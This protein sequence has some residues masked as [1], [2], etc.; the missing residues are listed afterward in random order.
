MPITQ[1][2]TLALLLVDDLPLVRR[3]LR[4]LLESQADFTV[5]GEAGDGQ[6]ALHLVETLSPDV[7]VMDVTMP[8]INGIE[9][10]QRILADAPGTRIVALSIRS[11]RRFVDDILKAG[12]AAYVLKDTAPEELVPAIHAVM[13]GEVFMSAPILS[14]VVSEYKNLVDETPTGVIE[15]PLE[16]SLILQTKLHRPALPRDLV[17]RT[18]LVS[19]LEK[20]RNRP[21]T[22]VSAP[23]GY[24]KSTLISSW[25]E[26]CDWPSA[27]ISLDEDQSDI[28]QFLIYFVSAV[29]GLFPDACQ[30]S[31]N[32]AQTAEPPPVA[33]LGNTL[34]NELNALEQP[35][36]LILDDYQRI[37]H[38]SAV[39]DLLQQLLHHPPIPLHLVIASRRDPPLALGALRAAG[40]VTDLRM[41]ELKFNSMEVRSL[42]EKTR[43]YTASDEELASLDSEMEGWAVGLRLVSI[44]SQRIEDPGKFLLSLRGGVQHTQEYLFQEVIDQLSSE[45]LDWLLKCA[46]LDRFCEGLCN[47]VCTKDGDSKI[48]SVDAERFIRA[49]VD[50][51][52]F[53]VSLDIQGHWYRYHHLFQRL[54]QT[55]L[56]Q[57]MSAKEIT[58]LHLRA[59]AWFESQLLIDEA[60][61]YA[62]KAGDAVV[63]ADIVQRHYHEEANQDRWYSLA[64]WLAKIPD[65]IV[66]QRPLL[67]LARAWVASYRWRQAILRPI[68]DA[69]ESLLNDEVDDADLRLELDF[70]RGFL[71]L[72]DG[73]TEQSQA[74]LESVVKRLTG[75]KQIFLSKAEA[76]LSF[77]RY[78]N[79]N[80]EDA[81]RA[82]NDRILNS[83]QDHELLLPRMVGALAFINLLSGDLPGARLEAKRMHELAVPHQSLM[84]IAWA[85]QLQGLADLHSMNLEAALSHFAAASKYVHVRGTRAE[86]EA[87][88]GIA[89]TQQLMRQPDAAEST[90]QRLIQF[91]YETNDPMHVNRARFTE[92]RIQLLQ[93]N[94]AAVP[95]WTKTFSEPLNAFALFASLEVSSITKARILIADGS[96]ESLRE[97]SDLLREM[98]DTCDT[99]RLTCQ[100]IEIAVLQS[101]LLEK[102]GRDEAA[103]Q[104]LEEA[105][106]LAAPGGWIRPF[107]EAGKPMAELLGRRADQKGPTHFVSRIIGEF[108]STQVQPA[109]IAGRNLRSGA[110]GTAWDRESLTPRELDILQLLAKRLQNKEIAKQLFVSP[111]TVKSHLK[112]LYQKLGVSNRREA[113]IMAAEFQETTRAGPHPK[114]AG[115][116]TD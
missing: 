96:I 25:L 100:A 26:D 72:R 45:L 73:N 18:K 80:G 89:L 81:V 27:W 94:L 107:V 2:D 56:S 101:L 90:I 82:I 70:F 6:E 8:K 93:G 24:G 64:R 54:L 109:R 113:G 48:P 111:E 31:R 20:H 103:M 66:Q 50:E 7:V 61:E 10:T 36:I 95:D 46:I 76:H 79:G 44:A 22:L 43:A 98:R 30:D 52:L 65:M 55:R 37:N 88:A 1:R 78:M 15:Q 114:V 33:D 85:L 28:Q 21:L 87:L 3:G 53:A 99:H 14:S 68:V 32:L 83:R 41:H 13:R 71:Q 57:H 60:I 116:D 9:A 49:L 42:L 105:L 97:A 77:A 19:Q 4:A 104:S 35:F 74:T 12:A 112:H 59:S 34:A 51:N 5:V 75:E 16:H 102:Q 67:L 84:S 69:V 17:S 62:M 23:A 39:N 91:A 40:Q 47:A 108:G 29:R 58:K 115:T 86:L 38:T 92:A 63:A 11:G 106:D 110:T